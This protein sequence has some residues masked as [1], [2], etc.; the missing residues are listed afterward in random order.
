MYMPY[1]NSF[2]VE[3]AS[4]SPLARLFIIEAVGRA[5]EHLGVRDLS[6]TVEDFRKLAELPEIPLSTL[7]PV[8][9]E[10]Q[11]ILASFDSGNDDDPTFQSWG[12]FDE[13]FIF[14]GTIHYKLTEPMYSVEMAA[15]I[16]YKEPRYHEALLK[17]DSTRHNC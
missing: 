14:D 5:I 4:A 6:F 13:V 2:H 9:R 8:V 16:L 3:F 12:I 7:R 11:Q 15:I 10:A 17:Y 1:Q